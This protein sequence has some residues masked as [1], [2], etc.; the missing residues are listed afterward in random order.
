MMRQQMLY[1][2]SMY[3]CRLALAN[4]DLLTA[5]TAARFYLTKAD[6]SRDK[7]DF[8]LAAREYTSLKSN[9]RYSET[10]AGRRGRYRLIDL[11]ILT[12]NY[13]AAEPMIERMRTHSNPLERAQAHY[14]SAL[15]AFQQKAYEESWTML[16][17]CFKFKY[18]HTEGRMLEGKLK[19]I[20]R[21]NID[22]TVV[23]VGEEG[24]R[25]KLIPGSQ[26]LL[27]I[28]DRNRVAGGG[29]KTIPVVV[30]TSAGKDRE[31]V[32]LLQSGSDPSVFKAYLP[33]RLGTVE[34]GNMY[35]ELFGEETVSY[36]MDPAFRKAR[37]LP[38][39]PP[40]RLLV[41]DNARLAASAGRILTQEEEEK[42]ALSQVFVR[43]EAQSLRDRASRGST[44]RPGSPLYLQVS[45]QDR[46]L[47][48]TPDTVNVSIKTSSGDYIESFALTET[49]PTT[50]L[51]RATCKTGIPAPRATAS[52]T[53]PGK[54]ANA[55]INST[56]SGV[57]TSLADGKQGKWLEI[58]TQSSHQFGTA[59]V[60]LADPG[61]IK[62]VAL[63][64]QLTDDPILLGAYPLEAGAVKGG[65][66]V[67]DVWGRSDSA[68]TAMRS[69]T[70]R[71]LA[72]NPESSRH[73]STMVYSRGA[74][75]YKDHNGWM[76]TRMRGRFYVEKD[77]T[78]D[79]RFIHKKLSPS[80]W[81][82]AYLLIDD[83]L[84]L[85]GVMNKS[86]MKRSGTRMLSAGLHTM[87]VYLRDH[88]KDSQ[89]AVG[90]RQDDGS[91]QP[92]PAA[93]FD[94][95]A[96]PKLAEALKPT[97]TVSKGESGFSAV[98]GGENRYR[99]LRWVFSSFEG[100]A[101][102]VKAVSLY[103]ADKQQ[104][105]PTK[106]DFSSALANNSLE[107]APG[108]RI[109]VSY[110]DELSSR[111]DKPVLNATLN[112]S[113]YNGTIEVAEEVIQEGPG[114][115]LSTYLAARRLR[116]GDQQIIRIM[117]FDGDLT[118]KA[119]TLD[120]TLTTSAGESLVLKALEQKSRHE[121]EKV[122]TGIFLATLKTGA[123]TN[124]TKKILGVKPGDVITA[125]YLDSENTDPGIPLE[126]SY[127]VSEAGTGTP[128]IRIFPT[129]VEMVED[130]GW[131]AKA[132]LNRMRRKGIDVSRLTILRKDIIVRDPGMG[133]KPAADAGPIRV[134]G[135]A[136]LLFEVNHPSA[137]LNQGSILEAQVA[138]SRE[139]A[140]AK[141]EGREPTWLTVPMVLNAL[142]HHA[143][144]KGYPVRLES[145]VR[146][147]EDELLQGGV[148]AGVVRLQ[149]GA[150]GDP[151]DD[152]VVTE[153]SGQGFGE[154]SRQNRRDEE[155]VNRVPT[156]VVSG[157]ETLVLRIPAAK[158]EANAA[159]TTVRLVS[160]GRLELLDRSFTAQKSAI[161]MG[162]NFYLQLTDPDQDKSDELD[163]VTVTVTAEKSGDRLAVQLVETLGHSGVFTAR[164]T[165]TFAPDAPKAKPG[166]ATKPGT[167]AVPKAA[168]TAAPAAVVK[169]DDQLLHARFGDALTFLYND[170]ETLV[171]REA[172]TVSVSGRIH[173]GADGGISAFTKQ[174]AD[175]EM[176]VKVRFLRAEALFEMAKDLRKLKK[177]K[178]AAGK[179]AEGR[180]IL[181]EAL[182]DYPNTGLKAQGAYLLATLS[183]ELARDEADEA[184]QRG[185]YEK[186]IVKYSTIF[187]TWP[188]SEY[189]AQSQYKKAICL[190]R[191]NEM[192]RACEEYV[193]LTYTFPDHE[194]VADATIRLGNYYYRTKKYKISGKVFNS[195]VKLHP[196]HKLAPKTL[197]LS[198]QCYLKQ[199]AVYS[200][201][202]NA[203][204]Q[205]KA[206]DQSIEGI[207]TLND[208][209]QNYHDDV[210][211]RSEAMYWIGD[212]WFKLGDY[213][214]AY[215]AF[216][217]L[218]FD[219]P[220]TVWAKR[221]RGYLTDE[222]F[223]RMEE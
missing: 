12:N 79:F 95:A 67:V 144:Y 161:H 74:T 37:N 115:M 198:A 139:V 94:P 36:Q 134:S 197:F 110:T 76:I 20:T 157:A 57:W 167:K 19:Y 193:K 66:S 62:K 91:F 205:A 28:Q 121:R 63:Y 72:Q 87:T 151:V 180:V 184:K 106:N 153:S 92:V 175:P 218:T 23:I 165:P 142:G 181:T 78:L 127:R 15:I 209:L 2:E 163:T 22:D 188:E 39:Y 1:K 172:S 11:H 141:A 99:K 80:N 27:R 81:Q 173:F 111:S 168:P 64:G 75:K 98:I 186:A 171:A 24:E 47:S 113:Y 164:L 210:N 201:S 103:D 131:Q 53:E 45:D 73:Q 77:Q 176:A 40:H 38:E 42:Q 204:L 221:A 212:T 21:K 30:T 160:T 158:N 10:K 120:V 195:F 156:L 185:L 8:P 126:R 14:F 101:L 114:G 196:E 219:Y 147:T 34:A 105:I 6:I 118:E 199:A 107:V 44:V 82:Y 5:E 83:E 191:M 16:K 154:E 213:R 178:Q 93:W 104:L 50:G 31:V 123:A 216:K 155:S 88:W 190:E 97:A 177:P 136:P 146:R 18:D 162:E 102:T 119:D 71:Y 130:D 109:E 4:E 32:K 169:T 166:A 17:N 194:L 174:F 133:E 9:R 51:F 48:P 56:R 3:L 148:F 122:H 69:Y 13:G 70:Q 183:Q 140:A 7:K 58:D 100:A 182:R 89:V 117:E 207:D 143:S 150:P 132:K 170:P 135:N 214:K 85:G 220:E 128:K 159:E 124:P 223:A 65:C 108:D 55:L 59:N 125:T 29:G 60:D 25:K 33:T 41:V 217:K 206:K 84:V 116:V 179:I 61:S 215:I 86:T 112:A 192:D 54:D 68:V 211:L 46:N 52:D 90:V 187:T 202:P 35:L 43:D 26:L 145:A 137:A 222:R 49:G 208:L 149:I 138:T 200:S 203:K 152:L 129:R 189:A 96:N